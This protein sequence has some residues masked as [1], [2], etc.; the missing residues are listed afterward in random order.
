MNEDEVVSSDE[1][2]EIQEEEKDKFEVNVTITGELP[3]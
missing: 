3:S 2:R 1:E